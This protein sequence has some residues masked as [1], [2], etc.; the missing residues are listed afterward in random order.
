VNFTFRGKRLSGLLTVLPANEASFLEEMKNFN[1]P[2][3]RSLKLKEVMGYDRHRLVEEGVCVSDL[4]VHGLQ[5]LFTRGLIDP[6]EIDA[7]ILVT[8]S[9]DHLMPPTSSVIQGRLALKQDMFCLDV[10]QGCA[11]F[12]VGLIEAFLLLEQPAVGKVVLINADVLS[13]KTS[14]KDRNSYPLIGDAASIAV[15]ERGDTDSIIHANLKMDG[16]RH[17]ALMIPAGGM[18][19]PSTAA[20][21]VLEDVGDKNLRAREHL[22]MD[23]SAV[24]NF[25]QIEV[26]PMIESLLASAGCPKDAVDWFLFHQP[27]RFMLQKL[28]DK[29]DV[30]YS[31]MPS[32]I[33][34]R[35]GNSSGVTIPMAIA[36]N[37]GARM[38]RETFRA[39]LAGFG[40]GLTW[41][42]ML[43]SLGGMSFCEM[44][45]YP[46]AAG[47]CHASVK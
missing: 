40:V 44:I 47:D 45:D 36:S 38:L 46:N 26:P 13:R 1:F 25:V 28:A 30:P 41:G 11:G 31:K 20:T 32:D 24:F 18:R 29:M 33:V 14:P 7:L 34:E 4:A 35:Y 43:L 9:P 21:A 10:N 5:Y 12:V 39:C 15:I 22:R 19:M 3:N 17:E 27:N 6:Q 2:I 16:T 23:G 42:S 8:Q 37:L